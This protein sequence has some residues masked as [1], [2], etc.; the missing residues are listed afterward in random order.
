MKAKDVR[1]LKICHRCNEPG[2]PERLFDIG[3][4]LFE[5][6]RCYLARAGKAWPFELMKLPGTEIGKVTISDTREL[7]IDGAK[8]MGIYERALQR[9]AQE[10]QS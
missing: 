6:P 9:D 4:G 5:H 8:L 1:R 2:L 3:A 7:A 10:G